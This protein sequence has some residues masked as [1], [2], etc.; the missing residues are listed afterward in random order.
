MGSAST[1]GHWEACFGWALSL[2]RREA[3]AIISFGVMGV[4]VSE[5]GC[6]VGFA[7][8]RNHSALAGLQASVRPCF[9]AYHLLAGTYSQNTLTLRVLCGS[10]SHQ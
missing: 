3:Q 10:P 9:R 1:T 5:R 2:G 6:K 8:I 7:V 4:G